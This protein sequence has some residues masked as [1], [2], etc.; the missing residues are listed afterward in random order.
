VEDS[1]ELD[2]IVY[3]A[4]DDGIAFKT[5]SPQ[6]RAEPFASSAEND[7]G[8][9]ELLALPLNGIDEAVGIDHS[10]LSDV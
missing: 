7:R 9:R 6:L 8:V 1:N 4:I 10:I 3:R 2:A 5:V